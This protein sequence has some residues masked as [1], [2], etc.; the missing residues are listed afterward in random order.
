[1]LNA[2]TNTSDNYGHGTFIASEIANNTPSNVGI[3]PIK[4]TDE[5][6]TFTASRLA[7]ALQY[8]VSNSAGV[9]VVNLSLSICT[10]DSTQ[11]DQLTSFINP[12]I[13]ALYEKGILIVTSAGNYSASY[14]SMTANDSYP[15]NY[16]KC[17]AVGALANSNGTWQAYSQ[18]LKGSCIDYWAPGKFIRGAK[19]TAMS[20][21]QA[22][23]GN[24]WTGEWLDL[25]D[26]TC[27]MSGTSQ[28]TAFV[29][30]AIAQILSYDNNLSSAEQTALLRK[31]S[32]SAGASGTYPEMSGYFY[33]IGSYNSSTGGYSGVVSDWDVLVDTSAGTIT[34]VKYT[35]SGSSVNIPA[36]YTVNG[37]TLKTVMGNST[38]TSGPFANNTVIKSVTFEDG[39]IARNNDASYMFYGCTGLSSVNKIPD[40]VVN[41]SY[42][43][44]GCTGLLQYP[45]VPS[46]VT[47]MNYMFYNCKNASGTST[48]SSPNVSS[49]ME[50]YTNDTAILSVP[51]NSTTYATF[52]KL[53]DK[54]SK[55]TMS[56]AEQQE[57]SA[58]VSL[59]ASSATVGIG[60]T[61]TLI[62]TTNGTGTQT[63]T[64]SSNAPAVATVNSNGVVTGVSTGTAI[65]TATCGS[66]KATCSVQVGGNSDGTNGSDGTSGSPSETVKQY[67]VTFYYRNVNVN[68]VSG[69][70]VVTKKTNAR[71]YVSQPKNPTKTGYYFA[72]W[73]TKN[74]STLTRFSF[75]DTQLTKDTKL[76]AKWISTKIGSTSI[77]SL[78]KVSSKKLKVTYKKAANA[79]HYQ[80][81]VSS[82]KNFQGGAVV[83]TTK[84]S[85]VVKVLTSYKKYVKVRAC[86]KL[87]SKWYYGK[88]SAVKTITP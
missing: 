60:K 49:G 12:Y 42:M 58:G 77:T 84:T 18:S 19:A 38:A 70:K 2:S 40:D 22:T 63:I 24:S 46:K 17:I 75:E 65:I 25:G 82:Y 74:G 35:G 67:I 20:M 80:I 76:Y 41:T 10:L 69:G 36:T 32:T 27:V 15:A 9:N 64:W 48:I 62:A 56:G 13:D 45:T 79:T 5:T 52:S 81:F 88:W 86:R 83:R 59:N 43:F 54:W 23:A 37:R 73:Y 51:A 14:P 33:T 26:G 55:V 44:Y 31:N 72:G 47:T 85:R 29:T 6:G 28:A 30:A 66:Y 87:G 11:M 1:V 21:T 4:V 7:A 57:T 39:V 53:I 71:G 3:I 34:L 16:D 8:L 78:K 50:A 61:Y 68:K